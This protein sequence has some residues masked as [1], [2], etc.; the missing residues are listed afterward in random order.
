MNREYNRTIPMAQ[1]IYQLPGWPLYEYD[2]RALMPKLSD[3]LIRQGMLFGRLEALGFHELQDAKLDAITAEVVKSSEIEGEILDLEEVRLSVASR[4]GMNVGGV[5]SGDYVEGVVEMAMDASERCFNPL[6]EERLF[7]W[8]AALFPEGRGAF[9]RL[10]VADWRD[11]AQGPM[12]VVSRPMRPTEHIHFEAPAAP[13]IPQ[14]MRTFLEWFGSDDEASGILKAGIAHLWFVT[15]HPF[16]DGNGRIGRAILDMALAR[17]DRRPYRCYSV[18]AQIRKERAGYYA[19][20][21][22]A[23]RGSLDYTEW[24]EWYLGCLDRALVAAAETISSAMARNRFWHTHN[25]KELNGRQRKIISRMLIGI[26]GKMTKR[27]WRAMA[28]CGAMTAFRDIDDLVEKGILIGDGGAGRST[29][30]VIVLPPPPARPAT[31]GE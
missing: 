4:L 26:E 17:A 12:Q 8:H 25:D 22:S 2:V 31:V 1:Y 5:P 7:G 27:K 10:R 30:Y 28:N 14:E 23:Q 3:V 20:L 9:G 18:S 19:A 29:A 21:E 15:I 6:D 11:D 24:L 16:E 13:L